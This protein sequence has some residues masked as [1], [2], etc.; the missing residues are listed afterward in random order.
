MKRFWVFDRPFH[1][2]LSRTPFS[3]RK[4]A[5]KKA[6]VKEANHTD[7]ELLEGPQHKDKAIKQEDIDALL[8]N[9][10]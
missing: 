6:V 7:E 1:N 3:T 10:D 9:F 5:L 2:F 8:V 4:K